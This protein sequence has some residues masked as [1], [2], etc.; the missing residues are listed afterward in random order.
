[1]KA[2]I[3]N[4]RSKVVTALIVL[5]ALLGLGALGGGAALMLGPQGQLLQMPVSMLETSPFRD[6]FIPG[7][8]L[9][10]LVG[11]FPM[12][13]AYSLWKLPTWTW[14]EAINP[15][16]ALHWS[17][18]GSLAAGVMVVVWIVVQVVMIRS[19]VFIHYLYIAWGVALVALTLLPQ[20]RQHCRRKAH[21]HKHNAA[22]GRSA[23]KRSRN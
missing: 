15:F 7:V 11:I 6:F 3:E 4:R 19:A 14:P 9:F 2:S 1:M 16:R 5:Q 12:L 13:V 10:C 22:E 20:A 18:A 21:P 17:W 23:A 8:L